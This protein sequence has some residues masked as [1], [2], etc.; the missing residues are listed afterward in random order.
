MKQRMGLGAYN[1]WIAIVFLFLLSVCFLFFLLKFNKG[2]FARNVI[3]L[4]AVCILIIVVFK[5]LLVVNVEMIHFLQYAILALL[6]LP[7]IRNYR[8]TYAASVVLGCM[9]EAYQY[10]VLN[11]DFPYF[12]FND[13]LLNAFGALL[14]LSFIAPFLRQYSIDFLREIRL[15]KSPGL[16]L[17]SGV[18]LL[19]ITGILFNI[20]SLY[21]S[22]GNDPVLFTLNRQ[23]F[24]T[25]FWTAL[26]HGRSY[27]VLSPLEG[28]VFLLLPW[29][30]MLLYDRL[31]ARSKKRRLCSVLAQNP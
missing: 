20:M 30:A 23:P 13:T 2:I 14:G 17:F 5:S 31:E 22:S 29:G 7:L 9:D 10:I 21:P 25:E 11:P 3:V 18:L 4:A 8:E 16:Y 15:Y 12:D 19:G 28:Y 26:Y 27:H 1:L 6:L 24:H